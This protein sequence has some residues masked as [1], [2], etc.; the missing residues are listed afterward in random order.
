MNLPIFLSI[1]LALTSL[2]DC[3]RIYNSPEDREII[4]D[5]FLRLTE[6]RSKNQRGWIPVV[7]NI[8]GNRCVHLRARVRTLGA[9]PTY[10]YD[11]ENNI[12]SVHGLE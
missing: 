7:I 10:C 4:E 12:L 3:D 6:G 9:S 1:M 11:Q 5:A 2:E 8:D